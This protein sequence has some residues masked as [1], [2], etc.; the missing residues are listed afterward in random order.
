MI[1]ETDP[2]HSANG[3]QWL[4][5]QVADA[6]LVVLPSCGHYPML[7]A[8]DAFEAALLEFAGC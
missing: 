2:V 3:A 5:Q 6:R 8:A 1:G 4:S 7:E